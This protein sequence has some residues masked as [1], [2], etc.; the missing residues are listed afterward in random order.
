VRKS[1]LVA[2]VAVSS[3]V[4]LG[5]GS[6]VRADIDAAKGYLKEATEALESGDAEKAQAKIELAETELEGESG[7][8]KAALTKSIA[9]LKAKIASQKAAADVPK[10][11]RQLESVMRDAEEAIGNLV[12]WGGAEEA[13]TQLFADPAAQ[14]ALGDDLKAAKKKFGTFK[15]LHMKKAAVAIAEQLDG[16]VK[17]LED[18]WEEGKKVFADSDSSPNSR[19]STIERMERDIKTATESLESLPA[20]NEARKALS[21]RVE[22]VQAEFKKV[23]LGERVKGVLETLNRKVE[24]Y[25]DD[26]D[27]WEKEGAGPTW[28]EYCQ[29][30]SEK[31]SAFNAPRTKVFIMR[32]G[33]LL[34][35]LDEDEEYSSVADRPEVAQIVAGLKKQHAD[36]YAKMLARVKPVFE[37]AKADKIT[38][39]DNNWSRLKDDIRLALGEKSA[40]GVIYQAQLVK[41]I[42]DWEAATKGAEEARVKLIADLRAKAN[43]AWKTMSEGLSGET[44][45]DLPSLKSGTVIRFTSDNLMGYRFKPGDFYFATTF[46]GHA[47]AAKVSP[48]V[49]KG[50][51]EIEEKIGRSLGD[52]DGDGKWEVVAVVTSRKAQLMARRQV[53]A[54]GQV[55]GLDYKFN[56]EYAEPVEARVIEIIAAKCGPFAGAKDKGVL[57]PDGTV[58]N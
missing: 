32:M 20:D 52:D 47:A 46:A 7:A 26:F 22:K 25:K 15:K 30:S 8:G 58:G 34:A 33:E 50:I 13:A 43:D 57:K 38:T 41:K 40:E 9:E 23:A 11:K 19:S 31:I 17:Q 28:Q 5:V 53:E 55:G 51:K 39:E 36:A 4:C 16:Q 42:A 44:D 21:A 56:G 10:Y 24:L 29:Q 2:A 1:S 49:M 27:G 3:V 18:Q 14:T 12:T 48:E 35:T 45:I 54:T 37:A 6:W